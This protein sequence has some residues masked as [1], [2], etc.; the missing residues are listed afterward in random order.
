[1]SDLSLD[2]SSGVRPL[3]SLLECVSDLSFEN[4]T[5]HLFTAD[6]APTPPH[7]PGALFHPQSD[8]LG[9]MIITFTKQM[10]RIVLP[11]TSFCFL[12]CLKW[13]LLGRNVHLGK[14]KILFK[15]RRYGGR[16]K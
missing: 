2:T 1:M 8:Y 9:L 14:Y 4:A 13:L 16:K 6:P 7:R 10:V 5:L 12:E 11:W 3:L 15:K